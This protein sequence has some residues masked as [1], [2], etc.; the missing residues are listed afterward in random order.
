MLYY[1]ILSYFMFYYIIVVICCI[2]ILFN[3]I[4]QHIYTISYYTASHYFVL[5]NRSYC[6]LIY[7]IIFIIIY[8]G[9]SGML[10]K[11]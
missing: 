5:Y 1:M 11:I 4:L 6:L 3:I 8:V 7:H 9:A 2:Y 10:K